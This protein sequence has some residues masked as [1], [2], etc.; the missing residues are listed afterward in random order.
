MN[1][2][3]ISLLILISF[4]ALAR[5][6]RILFCTTCNR[7]T[8]HVCTYDR[9]EDS[10]QCSQ[11]DTVTRTK[12]KKN[13]ETGRWEEV[14]KTITIANRTPEQKKLGRPRKDNEDD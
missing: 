3:I 7:Y 11:C 12:Y 8:K 6:D 1:F 9:D 14:E 13:S 10:E 4:L 2:V 5:K